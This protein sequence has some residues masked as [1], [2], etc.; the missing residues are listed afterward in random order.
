LNVV[1]PEQSKEMQEMFM[2]NAFAAYRDNQSD[3]AARATAI[4]FFREHAVED[5]K[6]TLSDMVHKK[7]WVAAVETLG[8][9]GVEDSRVS[10][11][12][13]MTL[14]SIKALQAR[15]RIKEE[16]AA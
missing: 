14:N 8:R 12:V 3:S 9:W 15:V 4:K 13:K 2:A 16:S 7:P 1:V 5:P 11:Q 10:L 6:L